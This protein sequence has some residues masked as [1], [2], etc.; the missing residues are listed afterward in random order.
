MPKQAYYG[1]VSY[2]HSNT[3][4][5]GWQNTREVFRRNQ[6][7]YLSIYLSVPSL[8]HISINFSL[9]QCFLLEQKDRRD[10]SQTT[11]GRI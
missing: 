7:I 5:K 3:F 8:T 1:Y 10:E 2:A 4:A 6:S 11:T 9:M